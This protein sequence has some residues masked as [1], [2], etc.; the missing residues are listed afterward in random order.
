MGKE[1]QKCSDGSENMTA[2]RIENE[3]PESNFVNN[4]HKSSF[5]EDKECAEIDSLNKR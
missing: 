5:T 1:K 3:I 2:L 4:L